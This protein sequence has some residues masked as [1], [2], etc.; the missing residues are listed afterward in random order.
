M[1]LLYLKFY[2]IIH[3]D[4]FSLH[5]RS[6]IMDNTATPF[7]IA[8]PLTID[9]NSS[10]FDR[11]NI[12]SIME[13]NPMGFFTWLHNT[14]VV[15]GTDYDFVAQI[16]ATAFGHDDFAAA[17]RYNQNRITELLL[18][19]KRQNSHMGA[20][21]INQVD[22]LYNEFLAMHHPGR[23]FVM[24]F[25]LEDHPELSQ[26]LP[27]YTTPQHPCAKPP[28][29]R[30]LCVKETLRK[31]TDRSGHTKYVGCGITLVVVNFFADNDDP[32]QVRCNTAIF[33]VAEHVWPSLAG[34]RST[35]RV[36]DGIADSKGTDQWPHLP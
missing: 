16:L 10:G 15:I 19:Y 7:R 4:D 30:F 34:K 20:E 27:F 1:I 25:G 9:L 11:R 12:A 17:K 13:K 6:K 32:S 26:A 3:S 5:L 31:D 33:D 29:M 23:K 2:V 28:F 8:E 36:I 35:V 18:R 22:D 21:F 14:C 24:P